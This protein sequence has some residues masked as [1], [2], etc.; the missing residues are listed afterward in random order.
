MAVLG[1]DIAIDLHIIGDVELDTIRGIVQNNGRLR[2]DLAEDLRHAIEE[3]TRDLIEDAGAAGCTVSVDLSLVE[4]RVPGAPRQRVDARLDVE[5]E[6]ST[7]AV[8]EK[9]LDTPERARI[10]DAA[11]ECLDARLQERN[12]TEVVGRNVIVPPVQFR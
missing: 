8:V 2:P 6:Q 11:E 12:L 9:A 10:S 5:G 7:L 1:S 4:D 3:T